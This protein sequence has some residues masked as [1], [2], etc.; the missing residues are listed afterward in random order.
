MDNLSMCRPAEQ[1]FQPNQPKSCKERMT[2]SANDLIYSGHL[3]CSDW[4]LIPLSSLWQPTTLQSGPAGC[5][6]G[7]VNIFLRVPQ[8]VGPILHLPCSPSTARGTP[9][10]SVSKTAGPDCTPLAP[11]EGS[12]FIWEL[13]KAGEDREKFDLDNIFIAVNWWFTPQRF[14][15]I[16]IS[17][18]V[19]F[20]QLPGN[21]LGYLCSLKV[22]SVHERA[23]KVLDPGV[24]TLKQTL[25]LQ[26]R[27]SP[28]IS[29]SASEG[30][31][32]FR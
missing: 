27:V 9:R 6:K 23:L 19:I 2:T 10:K 14:K 24:L 4:S 29:Q 3:V 32:T 1:S 22:H 13:N 11:P 15:K 17:K 20:S 5:E 26:V 8:S 31:L 25:K 12:R 16:Q 18:I 21:S 28:K 7:F 30:V